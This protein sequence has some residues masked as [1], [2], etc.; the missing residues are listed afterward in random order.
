MSN[1]VN[2]L[3]SVDKRH[4]EN[5]LNGTK[6]IELRRRPV[7]IPIGSRVW[8]YSKVPE[9]KVRAYGLVSGIVESS[10]VTIWKN[11]SDVS[12][13]S[14]N[15]F[16]EYFKDTE[17][18]CAIVFERISPLNE[19][20]SLSEMRQIENRFHPPQFFKFLKQGSPE[21]ALFQRRIAA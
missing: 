16:F 2:I 17:K 10:P 15:E 8:I 1:E 20:I 6:T 12:G 21:L 9:G 7:R 11:Y 19:T 18:A 14:K 3:I 4:V 5:M 13:V